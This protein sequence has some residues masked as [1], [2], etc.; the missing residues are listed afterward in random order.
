[1]LVGLLLAFVVKNIFLFVQTK[2]Q[3]NFV[4]DNQF[5]TSRKMMI[6]F[7]KRPYEYY[8]NAETAV[9]R[10]RSANTADSIIA[11][12]AVTLIF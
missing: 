8:L 11:A 7:M 2:L 1:M 5:E 10:G 9:L 6:N 4:Y 3:L 12:V